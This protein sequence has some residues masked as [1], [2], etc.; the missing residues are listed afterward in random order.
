MVSKGMLSPL[1][2]Q[3]CDIQGRLFEL[4]L[5]KGLFS[6]RFIQLFM[7]SVCVANYD[8]EYNRLQWAGEEYILEEL[9]DECKDKLVSGKTY[10]KD[11]MYWIGYT[12]RY[13]HFTTGESSKKIIKRAPAKIMKNGYARLHTID[14]ALAIEDLIQLAKQTASKRG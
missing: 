2:I 8:Q 11:E 4:S 1:Q 7:N 14:V 3:L 5:T 9:I 12:Y 10:T 6:E 13:W